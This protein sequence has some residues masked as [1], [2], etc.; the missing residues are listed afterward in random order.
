M[1]TRE[2]LYL[3]HLGMMD[4]AEYRNSAFNRINYYEKNS[5]FVGERL[6]LSFETGVMP[7]QRLSVKFFLVQNKGV[8]YAQNKRYEE[9]PS[10]MER[11]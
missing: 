2:E 3:E 1:R 6:I 4:D 11:I 7:D 10:V 5:I 9:N 8:C